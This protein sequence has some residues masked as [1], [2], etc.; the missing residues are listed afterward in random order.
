[1]RGQVNTVDEAKLCSPIHPTFQVLVVRHVV[2]SCCGE[3]LGPLC[4]PVLAGG[5][6]VF[7]VSHQFAKHTSEM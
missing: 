7:S 1:M 3:E 6:P 2:G 4:C 5:V